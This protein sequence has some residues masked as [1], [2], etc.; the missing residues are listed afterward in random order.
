MCNAPYKNLETKYDSRKSFYGKAKVQK[1]EYRGF[2]EDS[3]RVTYALWSYDTEVA[4]VT[5]VDSP[6]YEI[7]GMQE[8]NNAIV[9]IRAGQPQSA[10]TRRHLYDFLAQYVSLEYAQKVWPF[11]KYM[12][13]GDYFDLQTALDKKFGSFGCN[14]IDFQP[15]THPMQDNL[16]SECLVA[17]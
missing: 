12:K 14:L 16:K 7:E 5:F 15:F 2:P 11:M 13:N 1:F 4:T 6:N 3:K 10:T 8:Y 17:F 9:K